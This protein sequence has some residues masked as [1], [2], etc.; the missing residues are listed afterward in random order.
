MAELTTATALGVY[1]FI[2]KKPLKRLGP[3]QGSLTPS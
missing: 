3:P 1:S 2:N